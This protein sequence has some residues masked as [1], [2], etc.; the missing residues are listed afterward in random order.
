M[1]ANLEFK[2]SSR[3][4]VDTLS[5]EPRYNVSPGLGITTYPDSPT[6]DALENAE[7]NPIRERY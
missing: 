1:E 2:A 5:G 7:F 6:T 3:G 4:D